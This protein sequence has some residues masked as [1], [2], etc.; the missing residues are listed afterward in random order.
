MNAS[1]NLLVERVGLDEFAAKS[2]LLLYASYPFALL[3]R[4]IPSPLFKHVFDV[5]IGFFYGLFMSGQAGLFFSLG[6][7]VL[8]YGMVL[9]FPRRPMITVTFNFLA[10]CSCHMYQMMFHIDLSFDGV[11]MIQ[12][13]KCSSFA[14]VYYDGLRAS[15][16]L[17][18]EQMHWR[19]SKMPNVLEFMGYVYFFPAF[20]AGPFFEIRTY[21]AYTHLVDLS[22]GMD[23]AFGAAVS[24]EVLLCMVHGRG[25]SSLCRLRLQWSG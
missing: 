15:K 9:L 14:M 23:M 17:S 7:A 10:L 4:A 11:L 12:C 19:I 6:V 21:L 22:G 25:G 2:L 20:L 16:E 24:I 1:K 18:D 13:L 3:R 5:A 8:T